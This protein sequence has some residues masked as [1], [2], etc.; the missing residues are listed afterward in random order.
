MGKQ[1]VA[2]FREAVSSGEFTRASELWNS[3]AAERLEEARRGCG[4]RLPEMQ[5]LMEWTREVVACSRAQSLRTVRT[6]LMEAYA[7]GAYERVAH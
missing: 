5:E 2:R 3:Y 4:D 1:V 7:A 6:R